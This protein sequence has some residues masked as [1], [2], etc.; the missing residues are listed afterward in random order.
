MIN[1]A[2]TI[3]EEI[4]W[5]P[6]LLAQ[7][8]IFFPQTCI[9]NSKDWDG[10]LQEALR[11]WRNLQS[12]AE[13]VEQFVTKADEVLVTEGQTPMDTLQ[14]HQV[15]FSGLDLQI[16]GDRCI[17]SLLKNQCTFYLIFESNKHKSFFQSVT[18]SQEVSLEG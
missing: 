6:F 11:L 16:F 17:A 8:I 15:G 9:A 4:G 18:V 12:K 7:V 3:P 14:T 5:Y 2:Q 13:P 1:D 10:K